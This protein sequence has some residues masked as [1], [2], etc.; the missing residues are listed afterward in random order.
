LGRETLELLFTPAELNEGVSANREY[1]LGWQTYSNDGAWI[2][3]GGASIGGSAILRLNRAEG[4]A[5]AI[6]CNVNNCFN[7]NPNLGKLR[8][9]FLQ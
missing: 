8:E 9:L 7:S 4:V 1:G 2:G 3:H 6:L 5:Y